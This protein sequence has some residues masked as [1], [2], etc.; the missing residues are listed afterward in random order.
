M[1]QTQTTSFVIDVVS[2]SSHTHP[3]TCQA[4]NHTNHGVISCLVS[5]SVLPHMP[6]TN[7]TFVGVVCGRTLFFILYTCP[8]TCRA[9]N[10]TKQGVILYSASFLHPATHA[11]YETTCC[12]V[13]GFFYLPTAYAEHEITPSLVLIRA[14]ILSYPLE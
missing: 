8:T 9:Q 13:V 5:F 4:Q 2:P 10:H 14:Q 6:N 11:D 7:N 12:F 1:C 3:T